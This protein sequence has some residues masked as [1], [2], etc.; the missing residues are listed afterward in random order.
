MIVAVLT[1]NVALA[2]APDNVLLKARHAGPAKDSVVNISQVITIDK[3]CL[4][5]KVKKVDPSV[6]AEVDNGLRLVLAI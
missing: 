5:E 3:Q 1:S 4:T 6:M 2:Q